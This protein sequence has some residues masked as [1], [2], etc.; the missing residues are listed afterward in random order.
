MCR[1]PGVE[2]GKLYG[3][4]GGVQYLCVEA[5]V[6]RD[7]HGKYIS[8]WKCLKCGNEFYELNWRITIGNGKCECSKKHNKVVKWKLYGPKDGV[9]YL[10]VEANIRHN[11]NGQ[12]ISRWKC[13][14]CGNEF[15]EIN[16]CI[17]SGRGKC[18]CMKKML[19][20]C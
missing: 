3:P 7:K 10:C 13:L 9:Q 17:V 12:Y 15:D 19:Y 4:K 14:T 11:N 5:N 1:K 2:K 20:G 18:K 8:V 16:G 6:K